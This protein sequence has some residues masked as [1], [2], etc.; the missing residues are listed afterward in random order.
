MWKL[1][2]HC[3]FASLLLER[4]RKTSSSALVWGIWTGPFSAPSLRYNDSDSGLWEN[5]RL[6]PVRSPHSHIMARCQSSN[7][8][9]R[10]SAGESA[11]AEEAYPGQQ[12]SEWG[13]G[14]FWG[15][16]SWVELMAVKLIN[17]HESSE[18][19]VGFIHPGLLAWSGGKLLLVLSGGECLLESQTQAVLH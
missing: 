6:L 7:L 13:W 11:R 17:G 1:Q 12:C 9:P 15:L 16:L 3:S 10:P 18:A 8:S 4:M 2:P 14:M 19:F 5:E